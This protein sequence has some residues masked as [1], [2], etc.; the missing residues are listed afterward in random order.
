LVHLLPIFILTTVTGGILRNTESG[1]TSLWNPMCHRS[2]FSI[3]PTC[4]IS[5]STMTQ[6]MD[7]WITKGLFCF[8]FLRWVFEASGGDENSD[9]R[10]V[11]DSWCFNCRQ[12]NRV[13]VPRR[14]HDTFDT[15]FLLF[16]TK[17]PLKNESTHTRPPHF[18]RADQI[19]DL[20]PITDPTP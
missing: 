7:G 3:V 13:A 19:T 5:K 8:N 1:D 16:L 17:T 4:L 10:C 15:L 20:T 14:K 11:V 12:R 9:S 2:L 6:P 18:L